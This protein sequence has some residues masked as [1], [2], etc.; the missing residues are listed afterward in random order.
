MD[1]D[2]DFVRWRNKFWYVESYT[3]LCRMIAFKEEN[4]T[5]VI[6]R[7]MLFTLGFFKRRL[8]IDT[9]RF[10]CLMSDDRHL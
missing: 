1:L 7:K 8:M 2:E 6:L 3:N 4:L 5:L 10:Y 9:C